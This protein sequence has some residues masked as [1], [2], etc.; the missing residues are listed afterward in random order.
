MKLIYQITV[1]PLVSTLSLYLILNIADVLVIRR[2]HLKKGGA[3]FKVRGI[4]VVKFQKFSFVF[5]INENEAQ[6]IVKKI[7]KIIKIKNKNIRI[8]TTVSLFKC[9]CN[10]T[11]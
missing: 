6:N 7:K 11:I 9:L 4:Y 8:S 5:I 3:Y 10:H 2:Q 1:F